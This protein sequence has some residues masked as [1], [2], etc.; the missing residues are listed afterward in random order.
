[1]TVSMTSGG[2]CTGVPQCR[3]TRP[4]PATGGRV[5]SPPGGAPGGGGGGGG[6]GIAV[7]S[8]RGCVCFAA[9]FHPRDVM[10]GLDEYG[11]LLVGWMRCDAQEMV[12]RLDSGAGACFRSGI[13]AAVRARRE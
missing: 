8:R 13:G 2:I 12:T 11:G 1:M 6:G 3:L 7:Y 5:G 4:A 10:Q 9:E